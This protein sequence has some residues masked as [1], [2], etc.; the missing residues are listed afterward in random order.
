MEA[1][2]INEPWSTVNMLIKKTYVK[3]Y[4]YDWHI[5]IWVWPILKVEV[6]HISIVN[7]SQ[8]ATNI[9]PIQLP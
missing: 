8:M 4:A 6:M 1:T 7:I 9:G 2:V 3:L 5:Y